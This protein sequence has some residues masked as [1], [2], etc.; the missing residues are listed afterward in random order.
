MIFFITFQTNHN[1]H[2][3]GSVPKKFNGIL[4][5]IVISFLMIFSFGALAKILFML[6]LCV[7]RNLVKTSL[8]EK[9]TFFKMRQAK[10]CGKTVTAAY[11]I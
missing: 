4:S 6:L 8:G 9:K 5:K 11:C 10:E 3:F 2:V 7:Q 1:I